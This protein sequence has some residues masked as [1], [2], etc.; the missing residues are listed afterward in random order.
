MTSCNA[1]LE[2]L[3][4]EYH[5]RL[6][7]YMFRKVHDLDVIEDLLSC[8]Y[9]R[10]L[11]A[12]TNGNGYKSNAAAWLFTISRSVM[13][14]FWRSKQ[15]VTFVDWDTLDSEPDT[16]AT[17]H[18]QAQAALVRERIVNTVT[19]LGD[20]Y[21]RLIELRMEGYAFAEIADSMGMTEA[22]AK[23]RATRAYAAL[24][25]TFMEAA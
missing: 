8:V 2:T 15:H 16:V 20:S 10:A 19:R 21:P 6:Y 5:M 4:H 12:M 18:E 9:L 22:A 14:D 25:E 11:V 17:P 13:N 23:Q 3:W 1:D 7:A 24:R